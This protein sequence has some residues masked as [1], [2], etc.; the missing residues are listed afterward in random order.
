MVFEGSILDARSMDDINVLT[1][2]I[3]L[4]IILILTRYYDKYI[5]KG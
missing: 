5:K 2:V 3:G 1:V 4:G